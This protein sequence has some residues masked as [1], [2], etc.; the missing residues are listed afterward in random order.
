MLNL[1]SIHTIAD[2][3][4]SLQCLLEQAP[5]YA[6]ITTL[7]PVSPSAAEAVLAAIPPGKTYEDKFVLG[8]W[9]DDTLVGCVDLIRGYPSE[10]VAYIGL[11]LIAEQFEGSGF[12]TRAFERV[13][14]VVASWRTCTA[15]NIGVLAEN[16]RALR[17]WSKL[18]F[19]PTGE[20]KPY[21]FGCVRSDVHIYERLLTAA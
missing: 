13:I 4:A 7:L 2:D 15:F 19:A 3:L 6:H 10:S 14:E 21:Q 8:V 18:G 16:R 1:K 5:R 9:N 11:L 17:F 20:S 12:G